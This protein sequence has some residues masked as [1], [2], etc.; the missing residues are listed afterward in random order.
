MFIGV[1]I[2]LTV[3]MV[4]CGVAGIG[5]DISNRGDSGLGGAMGFSTFFLAIIGYI[6][7]LMFFLAR[8]KTHGKALSGLRVA[9]KRNGDL[10]GIG[11]ML[12]RETLGKFVSGFFLGLGYL[13]AIFDRD[14]QAWHDKIAG[15]VVLKN[16]S[17]STMVP[18]PYA[19]RGDIT[20]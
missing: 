18:V 15:T 7:L 14:S 12:L 13:S 19:G 5:A 8:G 20:S 2:F 6:V 11:R 10:P 3:A 9:D 17:P 4:S 1:A 16:I